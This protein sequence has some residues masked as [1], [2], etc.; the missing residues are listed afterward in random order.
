MWCRNI[1]EENVLLRI[2]V[3]RSWKYITRVSLGKVWKK[4]ENIRGLHKGL[5]GEVWRRRKP[6][7]NKLIRPGRFEI[8]RFF[9]TQIWLRCWFLEK[10]LSFRLNSRKFQDIKSLAT[11]RLANIGSRAVYSKTQRYVC[12]TK[13]IFP[14]N[15]IIKLSLETSLP[16]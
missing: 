9:S 16:V 3:R 15:T 8:L 6:K 12:V 13:Q 1:A 2:L 14:L 11:N 10:L 5:L 4:M 7:E